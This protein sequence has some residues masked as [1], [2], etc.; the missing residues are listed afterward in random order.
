MAFADGLLQICYRG[1]SVFSSSE[2]KTTK[3]GLTATKSGTV[4]WSYPTLPFGIVA[5]TVLPIT[6]LE[7]AVCV[8]M[9]MQIKL[10]VGMVDFKLV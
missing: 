5:C 8:C 7:I 6:F 2:R 9:V 1:K 3:V 4:Y 10:V